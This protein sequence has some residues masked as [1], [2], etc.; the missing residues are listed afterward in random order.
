MSA[1]WNHCND[2]I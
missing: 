2:W 1:G